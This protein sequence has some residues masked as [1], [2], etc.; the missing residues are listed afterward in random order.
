VVVAALIAGCASTGERAQRDT[1]TQ[2]VGQYAAPP[3]GIERAKVGV[4]PLNVQVQ[5]GTFSG[6][7][8]GLDELAADQMSTL[9]HLSRRFDVIER[10][11][12]EQL[13][14]EQDLEGIV[15]PDQ[16][17]RGGQVEGVDYLLIGRVTNFRVR[18]DRTQRGVDVGG[19]TGRL[20]G[21][22]MGGE[23]TGF[24]Q[25]EMRITTELGVDIRLVDPSTGRVAVQHFGEFTRTDSA[26]GMGI[27]V[28]GVQTEGDARVQIERDDAGK[29]MRLAFDDALRKMIR[30]IDQTLA[31]RQSQAV[32]R[33]ESVTAG[34][35]EA[36]PPQPSGQQP[37]VQAPAQQQQGA[38]F[39]PQCGGAVGAGVRFC[40]SCGASVQ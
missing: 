22:R 1:L 21:G 31:A 20:G 30:E 7:A 9:L 33:G 13:L 24:D 16:A 29:I 17:A 14:R 11:Q 18:S 32:Q 15:R 10:A 36:R 5:P 28:A 8:Q 23:S 6:S 4:P 19:L 25:R 27:R 40:P 39:C 34:T 12:L 38:R 3:S 37:G 35:P 2:E 26:Q